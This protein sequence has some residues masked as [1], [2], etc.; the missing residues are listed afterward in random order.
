M[1]ERHGMNRT[2]T[3]KSWEAMRQRC[4]NPSYSKYFLHGGRGIKICERWK[5]SFP[6][7][8]LDMG[9]RPEGKTL[10]RIDNDGNYE[11]KNCRWATPREQANNRKQKSEVGFTGVTKRGKLYRARIRYNG[12][13]HELG[14]FKT[15]EQAAQAYLNAAESHP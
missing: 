2:T 7:F 13:N 6:N 15:P 8:L 9:L 12:I 11:P 1:Y 14:L 5:N 4:L 10:D 3:H